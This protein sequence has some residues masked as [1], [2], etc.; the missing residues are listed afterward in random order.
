[1]FP[2]RQVWVHVD[3]DGYR[4]AYI[5]FGM[6]AI[7]AGHFL[8]HVQNR[9]ASRLRGYSHPYVRLCPVSR[10]VNTSG[11]HL[12]GGEGMEKDYLRQVGSSPSTQQT[13]Q[14]RSLS[15]DLVCADPMDLTKMLNLRPGT[16]NL[17]GVRVTQQ[18]FYPQ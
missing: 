9:E 7:P 13:L 3:Y 2:D 10:G 11:G 6:P 17:E 8:D 4:A 15:Y 18:L 5:S 1:M 16:G 14:A 12:A